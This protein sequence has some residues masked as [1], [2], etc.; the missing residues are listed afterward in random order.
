[1][2]V[3]DALEL[4]GME[5]GVVKLTNRLDPSLF[6]TSICCLR[7]QTSE[8]RALLSPGIE[9]TELHRKPGLDRRVILRLASL[10]RSRHIQIVHSHN[11][12]TFLYSVIGATLARTPVLIHGEHGREAQV[13]RRR[14]LL[15]SRLLSKRVDHVTTVSAELARELVQAWGIVPYKVTAVPNGVDLERFGPLQDDGGLRVEL[16]LTAENR[17]IL[18]VGRLRPVKDPKTLMRAFARTYLEFPEARMLLVGSDHGSGM[19]TELEKLATDLG[20]KSA[21]RFLG[22]RHDIPR[23]LSLSDVYVNSSVF[24]GMS[25]TILEAMAAG[26]PVVASA[27]GGNAEIVQDGVT[28]LLFPVGDERGLAEEMLKLLR[29]RCLRLRM[30]QAAR[31]DVER[32]HQ[33]SVMVN[34]YS[35]LYQELLAR[36]MPKGT[37]VRTELLKKGLAHALR[38]TGA[39]YLRQSARSDHLTILAYH[40]VLP[41]HEADRYPFTS[42]VMPRDQFEAQMA[43]FASHCSPMALPVAIERLRSGQLPHRALVVTF[44]DGYRDNYDHAFPIL[45]KYRVPAAFFVVSGIIGDGLQLWWDAVASQV[46]TIV[47]QRMLRNESEAKRFPGWMLSILRDPDCERDLSLTI[48]RIVTGL[49][50]ASATGRLEVLRSMQCMSGAESSG[51]QSLMLSW[52]QLRELDGAGMTIGSHTASHAFLDELEAGEASQQIRFSTRVIEGALGHSVRYFA[53]PAGRFNGQSPD[54]LRGAGIE[55]ALTMLPGT[56]RATTDPYRLRRFDA[57]YSYL[58]TGFSPAVLDMELLGWLYP[59]RPSP[60]TQPYT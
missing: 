23:L 10:L 11:W 24:E 44:D 36:R 49:N 47:R 54:L 20:V 30:G 13:T 21:V 7:Y 17:I 29:D 55:A 22:V 41:M 56:N 8:T 38:W 59:L 25:N 9:V 58:R 32:K 45:S 14:Q 53:Y 12:S 15:L 31:G 46:R 37:R 50:F 43:Y 52:D 2:H 35:G 51:S 4:A 28:G 5:Y 33:I 40:R 27:V 42:M 1:M 26:K 57:G 18:N 48:R 16:G 3:I 39:S 19:R 34:T 60:M 6:S